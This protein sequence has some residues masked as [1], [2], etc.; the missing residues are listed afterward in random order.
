MILT[1]ELDSASPSLPPVTESWTYSPLL[2][3]RLEPMETL[4]LEVPAAMKSS[5]GSLVLV[6]GLAR[7]DGFRGALVV[8]D[9][10]EWQK[11]IDLSS[12][13][14]V[15]DYHDTLSISI[16]D[17]VRDKLYIALE[18]GGIVSS[19]KWVVSR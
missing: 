18:D 10:G 11:Q 4:V 13:Q 8:G 9:G 19:A 2:L 7:D 3:Q 16:P 15:T 17:S 14:G 6:L 1:W 5:I 12:T